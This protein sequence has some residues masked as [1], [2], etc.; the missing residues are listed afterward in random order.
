LPTVYFTRKKVGH[1]TFLKEN[2][3]MRGN[4]SSAIS[5]HFFSILLLLALSIGAALPASRAL[6]APAAQSTVYN[7][8]PISLPPNLASLGFQ[9]TQTAEFGDYIHF[10]GT[11]RVLQTV[12]VTMSDW[13]MY[14]TYASDDRYSGNLTSWTHPITLNIYEVIPGAPLNQKGALIA[15]VTQDIVIPWRPEPNITECG[16]AWKADDGQC[17][18][19]LA[20]N[21]TFDMS[22]LDV[23]LPNDIIVAV[24]YNTQTWGADPIG[25]EGPYCSLNVGVVGTATVG[26]DDDTD[27]VF[28]NTSTASSYTDGGAAGVGIFRED[29]NWS[30]YGTVNF[31]VTAIAPNDVYVDDSWTGVL[32]G[33]DPD[34]A[35]P[36]TYMGS[37]AFTSINVA[38]G[39]VVTGGTI[40]VAA[41]TY[42]EQVILDKAVTLIGAG[43]S[44]IIQPTQ[45][46]ANGFNLFNRSD[47]GAVNTTGVIITDTTGDVTVS[48]LKVDGSLV[49][50]VPSGADGFAGIL[51]R[52][53]PGTIDHVT[54]ADI[55][56][57]GGA[58]GLGIYLS[59]FYTPV[60]MTVS[61]STVSGYGKNGITA[62]FENLDATLTGNTI[63]GMGAT[64]TIAQNG[65]QFGYGS[66]GIVDNNTITGHVW[67]GTYGGSNDPATDPEADGA[68][69]VLLYMS[70]SGVEIKNNTLTSNQFGVWSVAAPS[71]N[72]H[73][74][75]ISGLAHT[76]NV[77]P[78]AIAIWSEDMWTF[79]MGG[80]ETGTSAP[81]TNNTISSHDYGVIVRDYTA[82][83]PAPSAIL[84]GNT[85]SNNNTQVIATGDSIFATAATLTDNTFD[86][87]VTVNH[88]GTLLPAI[89]GKIQLAIDAAVAGDTVNIGAG[90]YP[91]NVIVDKSVTLAGDDATTTIIQPAV[92]DPNCGGAGGGSLCPGGSN[93]ILVQAN[94]VSIHDLAVD[95]DNPDLTGGVNVGGANVD[96]RNG[97]ITNHAL[98][99][100]NDLEV[101]NVDISNIYLRGLYASSG[102]TFYFHDNTVNNVQG[103]PSSIAIF[104]FGGTGTIESNTV[105]DANDAIAA[106]WSDGI[107]FLNNVVSQSGSGIHTDN[108][109]EFASDTPDLIE[110]NTISNCKADGYGIFVF[111]PYMGPVVN[112]NTI[113]GC[114]VGLSAWG[115]AQPVTTQFTNNTVTGPN[116]AVDSVGAYITTDRIGYGYSDVSV[117]F[118]NNIITNFETGVTLTADAQTWTPGWVSRTIN[119][120][121]HLNQ[122]FGNTHGMTEG[123]TG[124]YVTDFE[125]NWW[126]AVSGPGPVGLGT[127]DTIAANVDYL[128]WC[129]NPGCTTFAPPFATST[130]ITADN[131][132]PSE[133]GQTVTIDV[134]VVGLPA[135]AFTPTGTV[136]VFEG[137]APTST[138]LPGAQSV[139]T[140][141]TITLVNGA[142]S[143]DL[144]FLT[145]GTKTLTAVY[146]PDSTS[147][148]TAS[149]D[150]ESHVVETPVNHPPVIT[151]GSF[152]YVYMSIDGSP[153][154]FDLT[155]NATDTDGDS[156]TWS[157]ITGAAYGT[158]SASGTGSSK[159]ISYTPD[160]GFVGLDNFEVQVSDG[161][162]GTDSITVFVSVEPLMIKYYLPLIFHN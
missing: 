2:T 124:A 117:I 23:I 106:N 119:A 45:T 130:T 139:G 113:T 101:Y 53:N 97:I 153:N 19:G 134:T 7:A 44:T 133:I 91:E 8:L 3:K 77:Y 71:V 138:G 72:I 100:Y 34:G 68:S 70:G 48:N 116:K 155:L 81:I 151:Q 40:H 13:A 102:G 47:G 123:T 126:G 143:C 121:F 73:D 110:G 64:S 160:A 141:C 61:N 148:F 140:Y 10:G 52:G 108:A 58:Y 36:A 114:A 82:G 76:V 85:F 17:Y 157:V 145:G 1:I 125:K 156:L 9:A 144:T 31:Q 25:E 115:Q 109:G 111:V 20:F 95:G 87:S 5:R 26:D 49:T 63:T 22:G 127:G 103:D 149:S 74:N 118:S 24:A 96:A 86:R 29:T 99:V 38:N 150:T 57:A 27:R 107:Q 137:I 65:I 28:W 129:T 135:G 41:G 78:T 67:T 152:V 4:R 75:T 55:H 158:A 35:G 33:Q 79:D 142:G 59:G 18:N 112:N 131:P 16:T 120:T 14:S 104:A 83:D 105:T 39:A 42:N 94:N 128:P 146:A 89:W 69:G 30:P 12:T 90:T 92:S 162:G 11:N 21:A 56:N 84:N 62:N 159:A 147:D 50:S 60:S 88:T 51:F 46:T 15:S 37:D 6:A 93:V 80:T 54:V 32:P 132:D 66:S 98:G 136:T 161:K 43:D 122:I 154:P